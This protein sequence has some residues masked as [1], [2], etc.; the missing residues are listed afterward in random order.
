[1]Y[2]EKR[3][4]FPECIKNSLPAAKSTLSDKLEGYVLSGKNCQVAFWEI[5]EGFFCESHS[6]PHEEWGIVVS[7]TLELYIEGECKILNPGEEFYIPPGRAH[8]AENWLK[9]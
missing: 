2:H 5:K 7:G 3:N 8:W 4:H 9:T 6:H 1:M